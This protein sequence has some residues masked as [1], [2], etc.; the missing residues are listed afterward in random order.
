LTDYSI[1]ATASLRKQVKTVE[2][3]RIDFALI[4]DEPLFSSVIDA[5]QEITD[6]FYYNN[7]VI[8]AKT[9]PP[10]VSLLICTVPRDT[11]QQVIADLEAVS[12]V[13][14]PELTPTGIERSDGGYVMLDIALD[15]DLM[16]AHEAVLEVAAKARK[17]MGQDTYGSPYIRDAFTPHISLAKVEYRDQ[18]TAVAIGRK[19]FGDLVTAPVR[20]VDL[21]DIGERSER[22]EVLASLPR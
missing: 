4:P 10:H 11:L 16:A 8:D 14:L 3:C 19:A 13:G 1:T 21:C 9:F 22:W 18:A 7:N 12:K 5:S 2:L 17:D 6:E 15:D 20:S